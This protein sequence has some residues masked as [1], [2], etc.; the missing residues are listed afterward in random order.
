MSILGIIND[1]FR[2][3]KQLSAYE[4]A[5]LSYGQ[6]PYG[7]ASDI[8]VLERFEAVANHNVKYIL[9]YILGSEIVK[10][11]SETEYPDTFRKALPT[12][13]FDII[14]CVKNAGVP[15]CIAKYSKPN[16]SG[17]WIHQDPAGNWLVSEVDE[18]N[19]RFDH[20]FKSK[21]EAEKFVIDFYIK[22]TSKFWIDS[23]NEPSHEQ[24]GTDHDILS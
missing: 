5:R 1:W 22:W 7:K 3:R 12:T 15:H 16:G 14:E 4:V 13:V 9:N 10:G 2:I 19:F 23:Q 6:E 18:R 17:Y 21:W 24:S 11:M 20:Q 8:S